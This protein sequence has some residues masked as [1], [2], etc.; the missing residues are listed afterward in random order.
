V[1]SIQ[2]NLLI[3][4]SFCI[5]YIHQWLRTRS[6]CIVY[7]SEGSCSSFGAFG[8]EPLYYQEVRGAG[9]FDT[10]IGP[11]ARSGGEAG[12]AKKWLTSVQ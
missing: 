11:A 9:S 7:P 2:C 6:L 1:Y 4:L 5:V 10:L 12:A 8:R 3:V